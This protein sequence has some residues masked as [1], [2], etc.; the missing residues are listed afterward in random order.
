[1]TYF[2]RSII[3]LAVLIFSIGCDKTTLPESGGIKAM[4]IL[5]EP[6]GEFEGKEVA[7]YTLKN[8]ND[9][10]VKITS[11]GGTVTSLKVPD[12][13]G[14]F[15]D[16]V[17]GFN[18]LQDY[19]NGNAYFGAIV[20]RYANRIGNAKFSIDG[21]EYT[22][23]K[24]N[25]RN[26]LHGGIKGFDKVL[27]DAEP[28][29]GENSQSLKLHYMSRDGEEGFPG[30]LNVTVTYTL[31]DDNS[32]GI[33]YLATTDKPTVVN[34]TNHTYWNLAGEGSGDILGHQLMLNADAFTP[35]D[36]GAIPTGEIRP[37]EG[38][39][40]DFRKPAAVGERIDSDYEQLKFG[41]GY[42]HNWVINSGDDDKPD[43]AATVYE[44]IS[45]RYMEVLTTE[46]GVQFYSG[47]Y[48]NASA[49]KSG[50]P[51]GPRGALCL[52]TQHYPD[53][54]NKPEFP[55]VVLNPGETYRSTTIYKFS[56]R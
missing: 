46:P 48:V 12:K 50:K 2:L 51:Y 9:I 15:D 38:A 4:K 26:C 39:P 33:D 20:G 22:L 19:L 27:W 14:K 54:P 1:M 45:G 55:S 43:L 32:F 56:V 13:N 29:A 24:N 7:V 25:W 31:T 3:I 35:T 17:L 28:I 53:S 44:P 37:V 18:N 41:N 52:E 42:D 8:A 23:T 10:E 16:V 21:Q 49:G 40:M 11:Y 47:N 6:F 30:N 34:L 5:K 36:R